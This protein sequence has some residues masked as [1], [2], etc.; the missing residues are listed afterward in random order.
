MPHYAS[1]LIARLFVC[2][3]VLSWC[4]E[5]LSTISRVLRAVRVNQN[6]EVA[7]HEGKRI[8]WKLHKHTT[9]LE[10]QRSW[11]IPK[12][13]GY[14]TMSNIVILSIHHMEM[15]I[16]ATLPSRVGFCLVKTKHLVMTVSTWPS[17]ANKTTSDTSG[18]LDITMTVIVKGLVCRI[19]GNLKVQYRCKYL[20]FKHLKMYLNYQQNVKQYQF[21]QKC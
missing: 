8:R 1:L 2:C 10:A 15:T 19:V 20:S 13:T 14:V 6:S 17:K 18:Y 11:M 21:C 12:W 5:G 16:I 7:R 4:S 9:N 3:L